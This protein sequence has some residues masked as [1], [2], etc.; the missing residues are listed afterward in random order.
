MKNISTSTVQ[1]LC[2]L[3]PFFIRSFRESIRTWYVPLLHVAT[4]EASRSGPSSFLKIHF[5]TSQNFINSQKYIEQNIE[6]KHR[7]NNQESSNII[8]LFMKITIFCHFFPH[9][10]GLLSPSFRFLRLGNGKQSSNPPRERTGKW[11]SFG[12]AYWVNHG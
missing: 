4:T 8:Q 12:V 3:S 10:C 7:I 6:K 5:P 1:N 11:P 9:P 2:T